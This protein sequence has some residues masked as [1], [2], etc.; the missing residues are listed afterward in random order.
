MILAQRNR[1]G[2]YRK[3]EEGKTSYILHRCEGSGSGRDF[4]GPSGLVLQGQNLSQTGI[5]KGEGSLWLRGK[6]RLSCVESGGS[7]SF[8]P[9]VSKVA[10]GVWCSQHEHLL[11]FL[12]LLALGF[13]WACWLFFYFNWEMSLKSYSVWVHD[14]QYLYQLLQCFEHYSWQ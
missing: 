7:P 9:A 11:P 8:S 2:R 4:F 13:W 10:P 14:A 3:A 12:L 6:D 1:R 5:K